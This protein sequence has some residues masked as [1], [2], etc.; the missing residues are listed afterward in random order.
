[1]MHRNVPEADID[2][3][4]ERLVRQHDDAAQWCWG[5]FF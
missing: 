4:T 5:K 2:S 3:R 1:M